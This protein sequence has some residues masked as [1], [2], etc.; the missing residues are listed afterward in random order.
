[1]LHNTTLKK[2]LRE[3]T[4]VRNVVMVSIQQNQN[5]FSS[6]KKR[7]SSDFECAEFKS[8]FENFVSPTIFNGKEMK[9]LSFFLNRLLLRFGVDCFN[10]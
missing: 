4:T 1:L 6:L 10:L 9:I 5:T 7:V 8:E 3:E 2:V